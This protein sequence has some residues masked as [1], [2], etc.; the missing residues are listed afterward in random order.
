MKRRLLLFLFYAKFSHIINRLHTIEIWAKIVLVRSVQLFA[1]VSHSRM[2]AAAI[3][4][5]EMDGNYAT[6][7]AGLR[8]SAR[9]APRR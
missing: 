4:D 7:V 9:L 6:P 8:F 5:A 3:S 1:F 2:A